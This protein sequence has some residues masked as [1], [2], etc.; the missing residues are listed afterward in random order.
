MADKLLERKKKFEEEAK[1]RGSK[2]GTRK[3]YEADSYRWCYEES[4]APKIVNVTVVRKAGKFV[5][6]KVIV[7]GEVT[8]EAK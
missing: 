3:D 5:K 7:D 8:F 1:K 4:A 6:Q 2:H